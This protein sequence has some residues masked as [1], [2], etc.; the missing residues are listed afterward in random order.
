M[1]ENTSNAPVASNLIFLHQIKDQQTNTKV[2]FLC[3]TTD[4][5]E[6]TGCLT[7]EHRYSPKGTS[8]MG[9][10]AIVDVNLI[11]E[12]IK[13]PLL[14]AGSWINIIGYVHSVPMKQQVSSSRSRSHGDKGFTLPKVK[15][16]LLWDAGAVQLDKYENTIEHHLAMTA[17]S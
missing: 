5:D 8:Q 15:A 4:Y 2:R 9:T 6:Q 1:T 13:R 17:T 7:V 3:C 12:T 10:N 16:I 11:L 14:Q